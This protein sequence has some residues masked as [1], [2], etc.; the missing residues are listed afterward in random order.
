LDADR[1]D[2]QG[3]GDGSTRQ[4]SVREVHRTQ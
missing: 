1:E 2:L 4:C 3:G